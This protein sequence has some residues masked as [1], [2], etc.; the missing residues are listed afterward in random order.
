MGS[1]EILIMA[2]SPVYN[3]LYILEIF[4]IFSRNPF[5]CAKIKTCSLLFEAM[6]CFKP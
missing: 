4:L 5:L 3:E 2:V 6:K 1:E